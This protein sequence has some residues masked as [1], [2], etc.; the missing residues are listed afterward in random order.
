MLFALNCLV[1]YAAVR[2][3]G[4]LR[5]SK[6]AFG[7]NAFSIPL[8]ASLAASSAAGSVFLSLS[9]SR[10]AAPYHIAF[11][12]ILAASYLSLLVSCLVCC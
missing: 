2:K 1:V 11:Q 5:H 8:V 3:L 4:V 7:S 12:A 9:L 10:G 6:S